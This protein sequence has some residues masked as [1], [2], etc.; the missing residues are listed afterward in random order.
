MNPLEKTHRPFI[1]ALQENR[2]LEMD[3]EGNWRVL[4]SFK[5]L[6][7]HFC[8]QLQKLGHDYIACL[9]LLESHPIFFSSDSQT[10]QQTVNFQAYQEAGNALLEKLLSR[11]PL[12]TELAWTLEQRLYALNIRLEKINGGIDPDLKMTGDFGKLLFYATEWKRHNSIFWK[13]ELSAFE[14]ARIAD[15]RYFSDYIGLLLK[16]VALRERFFFWSLRNGLAIRPFIQYP[17]LTEKL[18]KCNLDTRIGRLGGEALKI[19]KYP[20]AA[21]PTVLEKVVTLPFEGNE[22]NILDENREVNLSGNFTLSLK[23]VYATFANKEEHPGD[24]EFFS[25]GIVNWNTHRLGKWNASTQVYEMLDMNLPQWW[26]SLP[27]FEILSLHD[28][29]KRYGSYVDGIGWIVVAQAC[30]EHL[31]LNYEKTH[32]YLEVVV[33]IG[34]GKY[35]VYDFGKFATTF[36]FTVW[37]RYTS[38]A[39]THPGTIAYPDENVYMTQRQHLGL[40]FFLTPNEGQ[41]LMD[42][43]RHDILAARQGN[44]AYQLASD[45]CSRWIQLTLESVLGKERTPNLFRTTLIN[46]EPTGIMRFCVKAV[47]QLPLVW[48]SKALAWLLFPFGA[49]KGKWIVDKE[50]RKEWISMY[51]SSY[52]QDGHVYMPAFLH[53]QKIK[54]NHEEHDADQGMYAHWDRQNSCWVSH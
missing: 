32:A 5:R 25:S 41:L 10:L 34:H 13:K 17:A 42:A 26:L 19:V 54:Q 4:P 14:Y 7:C 22:I 28:T 43:I 36:T 38:F 52:W 40:A 39:R 45:N 15:V 3:V 24:L 51:N 49:W 6:F 53:H 1:E 46:A 18:A 47:R 50:G 27:T 44:L 9:D 35:A 23:Q 8:D 48:R 31:T 30:R 21:F 11:C 16:N 2:F 33:P 20:I 29:R 37:N 12:E